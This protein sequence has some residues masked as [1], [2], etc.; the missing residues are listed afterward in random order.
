M[1]DKENKNTSSAQGAAQP[2][3][4][5][6]S[7]S[8]TPVATPATPTTK[9][10]TSLTIT[11]DSL[12]LKE[13][14]SAKIAI[15]TN[16]SSF[17]HEIT[18]GAGLVSI[19]KLDKGLD[20]TAKKAGEVTIAIKATVDGGEEKSVDFTL[21][22]TALPV[23]P[24]MHGDKICYPTIWPNLRGFVGDVFT[25]KFPDGEDWDE[26]FIS[27]ANTAVA[28]VDNTKKEVTLNEVST[29]TLTVNLKKGT[30]T[31]VIK[32][33]VWV[34]PVEE[35]R[36]IDFDKKAIRDYFIQNMLIENGYKYGLEGDLVICEL[37]E[38]SEAGKQM[39][40]HGLAKA[41]L[42]VEDL[43]SGTVYVKITVASDR[44]VVNKD[45]G[46]YKDPEDH[47]EIIPRHLITGYIDKKEVIAVY[48][49]FQDLVRECY[50]R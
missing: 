49:R 26:V 2:K 22:I 11:P 13:G 50:N 32:V 7:A 30:D 35:N 47:V 27:S 23:N 21:S 18:K 37:D 24:S 45:T 46:G 40:S 19:R 42:E 44:G 38:D 28:Y 41:K 17:S 12:Q 29:T 43:S 9:P 34:E 15:Y 36:K 4:N 16:A 33:P 6:A 31:K 10:E 39:K 5:D 14:D 1:A 48:N 8:G 3:V 20:I 25:I